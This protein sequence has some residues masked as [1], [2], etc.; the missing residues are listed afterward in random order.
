MPAINKFFFA[1]EYISGIKIDV[2]SSSSAIKKI[3][4]NSS[5]VPKEITHLHSDDP[6]M[7]DVFNQLSE[8]FERERKS[9]KVP[10]EPDGTEFQLK[11]WKMVSKIPYGKTITYKE[12]A[13]RMGNENTIRAVGR[14]NGANPIPIIIPCHRVIGS[15]GKLVGYRGG[16]NLKEKLL[17]LEGSRSPELFDN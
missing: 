10:V 5:V 6:Y 3:F 15:D 1:T 4:L 2:I 14:A 16:I 8:Y 12:L 9:F 17:K 11:V 13:L 7:F